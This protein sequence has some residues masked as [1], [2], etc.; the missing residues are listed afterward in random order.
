MSTETIISGFR[1]ATPNR[2][3][4]RAMTSFVGNPTDGVLAE[5]H[6][7]Y[8]YRRVHALMVAQGWPV[9][10]KR[11]ERLWRAEGL[12][13]PPTS[14]EGIRPASAGIEGSPHRTCPRSPPGTSRATTSPRASWSTGS[15]VRVLVALDEYTRMC[16]GAWLAR[17]IGA[18]DIEIYL[19]E[20]ST[21]T[22]HGR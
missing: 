15:A 13:I 10:V 16:V 3:S 11:I 2:P 9:N 19:A 7:R 8:G 21:P 20:R 14:S 6:P 12:R 5:K 1:T 22:A 18:R 17:S 4:H